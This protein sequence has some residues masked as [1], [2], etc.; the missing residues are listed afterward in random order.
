LSR[1]W[2][3]WARRYRIAAFNDLER[4]I[5][6]HAVPGS[7]AAIEHGLTNGPVSSRSTPR[8]CLMTRIVCS[9]SAPF[10]ALIALATL[11]AGGAHPDPRGPPPGRT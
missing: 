9:G 7:L 5:V 8:V 11:N 3:G 4:R 2:I 10:D 6:K 1:T